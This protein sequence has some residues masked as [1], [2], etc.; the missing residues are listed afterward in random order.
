MPTITSARL[1]NNWTVDKC[2]SWI[3]SQVPTTATQSHTHTKLIFSH[4]HSNAD[5]FIVH[6]ILK[7]THNRHNCRSYRDVDSVETRKNIKRRTVK[8]IV[9]VCLC[10][11][12][13][14]QFECCQHFQ[15][16]E[17]SSCSFI[18]QKKKKNRWWNWLKTISAYKIRNKRYSKHWFFISVSI[19]NEWMNEGILMEFN[20]P[21]ANFS[22]FFF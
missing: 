2:I 8:W 14:N 17:S 21:L 3:V 5:S 19:R 11:Y 15:H 1:P 20:A 7:T 6:N 12:D 9:C 4:Y 13:A 10:I 16:F 22:P 18:H